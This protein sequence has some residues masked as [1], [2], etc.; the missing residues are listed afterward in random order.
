MPVAPSAMPSGS[1]SATSCSR[2][3]AIAAGTSA[4]VAQRPVLIST[5]DAISSPTRCGSSGV[6]CGRGLDLLEPVD[7]PERRRVEQRELLL[8]GDGEVRAAVERVARRAEQLVVR[9]PLLVTHSLEGS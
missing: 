6:P 8:D 4:K 1:T 9:Q 3:S 7:E 2:R 5:S